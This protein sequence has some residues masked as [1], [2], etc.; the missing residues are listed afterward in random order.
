MSKM[1]SKKQGSELVRLARKSIEYRLATG[2]RLSEICQDNSYMEERGVFVTISTYPEKALRGCIGF[3]YPVKP[4]WG[5]VIEAAEEAALH[6][7]RFP[8]LKAKELDNTTIE[9]SILTKPEEVRLLKK[10]IPKSLKI[11]EDGL[12]IQRGY[13]SGLLLPQVAAEQ[14]WKAETFLEA[15]S[16]KAGLLASMWKSEETTVKK[17]QAQVFKETKPKGPV[18]ED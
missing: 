1:F 13:S 4:L 18:E 12:I 15:C 17:F 11:G 9:A 10:E 5:A 7:P 3:P 8:P 6:D 16:E 2:N 14:G